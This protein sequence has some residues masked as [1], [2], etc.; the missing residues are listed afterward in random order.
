MKAA[1]LLAV[2]LSPTGPRDQHPPRLRNILDSRPARTSQVDW[3]AT[4]IG[5]RDDGLVERYVTRQAGDAIWE[6]NLGDGNGYHCTGFRDEPGGSREEE[7]QEIPKHELAGTRNSL[8]HEGQAW[9]LYYAERPLNGIVQPLETV[10]NFVPVNLPA[11]GLAPSWSTGLEAHPLL[12]SEWESDGF[13]SASFREEI[14]ESTPTVIAEYGQG[15]RLTWRFDNRY[16][17]NPVWAGLEYNGQ[18]TAYSETEYARIG[19]RWFP[20]SVSFYG[21]ASSIPYKRIDVQRVTWDEPWHI[22]EITP[23]DIG[24]LNG[25][26]FATPHAMMAW[27]GADLI[28][29]N[30]Y[31]DLVNLNGLRSDARILE[32]TAESLGKPL[33]EY[34]Q[35]LERRSFQERERYRKKYGDEPWLATK[36]VKE[37]DEWDVYVEKFIAEHKLPEPGVKRAREVLEQAK[38]LRDARRRQNASSIREAEKE[39]DQRKLDHFAAVEKKM[40]D[41]VLVRNLNKLIPKKEPE[42]PTPS[43]VGE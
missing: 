20:K 29:I 8:V 32:M 37:K 2:L 16:D 28:P 41:R 5:G 26:Q 18:L 12:L 36:P 7:R 9:H 35:F 27:T 6:S 34:L 25:T 10:R 1:L 17:G 33:A 42:A 13:D 40:F 3:T 22:Q 38:N 14:Q 39:K 24:A 4:W 15:Y 11:I 30:E 19:E 23:A 31:W 21:R 43:S